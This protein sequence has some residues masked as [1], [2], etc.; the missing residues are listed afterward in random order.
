[1]DN[2]G[3]PEKASVQNPV[4]FVCGDKLTSGY[5]LALTFSKLAGFTREK[6][7]RKTSWEGGL[8]FVERK[9]IL[10]ICIQSMR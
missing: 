6:Q 4:N 8:M 1:M 3:V 5:H 7:M 2:G 10:K 9:K